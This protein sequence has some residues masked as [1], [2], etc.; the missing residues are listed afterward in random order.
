MADEFFQSAAGMIRRDRAPNIASRPR[1]HR[2]TN[3]LRHRR[4]RI[5]ARS[6]QA[7]S[8]VRG[9]TGEG[10]EF[11]FRVFAEQAS[12]CCQLPDPRHQATKRP[13][14]SGDL[15]AAGIHIPIIVITG[16]GDIPMSVRA[17]KAGAIDFLTKSFR[18]QD[19]LHA[20][21]TAIERD[22]RS[23]N[24][25]K[26][27]SGLQALFATLSPRE[28]EAMAL[29]VIGRMNKHIGA[30]IGFAE[31]AVKMHRGRIMR[32]M[33]AKSLTD[34]VRMAEALGIGSAAS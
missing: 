9:L 21:T 8:P 1:K 6:A 23:C 33:A 16:H 3:R 14:L 34:P 12:G 27:L 19:I 7:S 17:M 28:Q 2:A 31:I 4:R 32:K 5:G 18:D 22:R 26:A 11:G 25:A 30:E 13:R 29:V 15:A 10:G 24:D 20:V